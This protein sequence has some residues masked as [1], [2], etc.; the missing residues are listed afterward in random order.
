MNRGRNIDWLMNRAQRTVIDTI[1]D[2]QPFVARLNGGRGSVDR[3]ARTTN[4]DGKPLFRVGKS[5]VGGP[6]VVG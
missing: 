2:M 3:Q 4:E 1:P 6:E 5:K